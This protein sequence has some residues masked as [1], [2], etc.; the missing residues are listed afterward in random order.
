MIAQATLD[1]PALDGPTTAADPEPLHAVHT[2]NFPALL[3]Q[4]GASLLVTT[5][6]AGRL[7]MVRAEGDHLNTHYRTFKAPMGLALADGGAR[8]ALGTTIQIWEFR[9]VPSVA[10]RLEP[11]AVQ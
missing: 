6:Q 3:R 4:L 2:P 9:D 11:Q 1:A 5:Y 8:L 10:R 7:V